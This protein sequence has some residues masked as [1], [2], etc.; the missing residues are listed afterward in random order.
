MKQRRNFTYSWLTIE[1]VVGHSVYLVTYSE[2]KFISQFLL[3]Y[4]NAIV[5]IFLKNK[6]NFNTSYNL[7][8]MTSCEQ[9][10]D[11]LFLLLFY[12]IIEYFV[13]KRFEFPL[14][15]ILPR[16]THYLLSQKA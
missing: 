15:Y 9:L 2:D 8:K 5:L 4:I 6:F 3:E 13:R 12:I 7:G 16:K 10:K 14:V 11:N 1:K